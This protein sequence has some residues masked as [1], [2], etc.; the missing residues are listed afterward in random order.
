ML[1]NGESNI[2]IGVLPPSFHFA[3]FEPAEVYR[4]LRGTSGCDRSRGCHN[5]TAVARLRDGIS[6][7]RRW[8]A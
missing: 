4:T 6:Q 5:L 3:P 7:D 1:L 8:P 2:I